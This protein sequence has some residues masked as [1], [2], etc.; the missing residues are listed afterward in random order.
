ME[1]RNESEETFCQ[2]QFEIQ[3]ISSS[4]PAIDIQN[5][6]LTIHGNKILEDITLQIWQREKVAIIGGSGSG[7]H[8][9]FKIIL[10]VYKP[11]A[12]FDT[13]QSC[14]MSQVFHGARFSGW[15]MPQDRAHNFQNSS[16]RIL[17]RT[18]EEFD[19]QELRSQVSNLDEES[20]LFQ[21][22]LKENLDPEETIP[23]HVLIDA[24]IHVDLLGFI[25]KNIRSRRLFDICKYFDGDYKHKPI[26]SKNR[27]ESQ[28]SSV[29]SGNLL[30]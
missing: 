19:P 20:F 26:N 12:V 5:L 18:L 13:R 9:I 4:I 25:V 6:S 27:L 28:E 24:L 16:L 14:R 1:L 30:G 29:N 23:I 11:N 2:N 21:G 8:S 22:S 10:G 15:F 7:K 17:G 3:N